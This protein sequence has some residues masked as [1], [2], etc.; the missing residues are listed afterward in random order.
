MRYKKWYDNDGQSI[1][2]AALILPLLLVFLFNAVNVGYFFYASLNLTTAPRQGAEYAIQGG[3]SSL[4]APLPSDAV[5]KA[6]VV[7]DITNAMSRTT[8]AKYQVCS[9]NGVDG[10]LVNPGLATQH[11]A[12]RQYNSFTATAPHSDP[13]SPY[14][15]LQRVD[16]QYTVPP[17]I[18]GTLFNLVGQ[19]TF[20]RFVEMRALE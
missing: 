11:T 12:C 8:T 5:V 18:S 3:I 1:I 2:E 6:L 10:G 7:S 13:E 14:L 20:H 4:Q 17:L 19:P 15:V 16:I 9:N